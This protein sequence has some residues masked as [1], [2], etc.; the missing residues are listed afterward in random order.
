MKR[1]MEDMARREVRK[2]RVRRRLFGTADRPRLTVFRSNKNIYAQI[3]DDTAGRTIV[4]ASTVDKAV[5]GELT[6]AGN[7]AAAAVVGRKLAENA[8]RA[9][10][11]QVVFDRDGYAYHGRVKELADAA[12]KG[13]LQF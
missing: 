2:R 3:I 4:A 11:K 9:G 12:R 1:L 10:I 8:M 5:R 7:K 6:Y 13:G